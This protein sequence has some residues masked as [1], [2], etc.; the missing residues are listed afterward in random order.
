MDLGMFIFSH[1][2]K[3]LKINLFTLLSSIV[4]LYPTLV[5]ANSNSI[6]DLNQQQNISEQRQFEQLEQHNKS[7]IQSQ[8]SLYSQETIPP[9]HSI[10]QNKINVS[11][12]QP[13]FPIQQVKLNISQKDYRYF[14]FLQHLLNQPKTGIIGQCIGSDGLQ[15]ILHFSQNQ[16]LNKGYV[17]SRIILKPQDLSSGDLILTVIVGKIANIYR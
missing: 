17:T 4:Y 14:Y 8:Q 6:T 5:F 9:Q 3:H 2:K 1:L 15:Q 10:E 11:T 12:E 16:L 13:C 7:T